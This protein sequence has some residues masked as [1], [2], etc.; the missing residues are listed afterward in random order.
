MYVTATYIPSGLPAS[1]P[2]ETENGPPCPQPRS[3]SIR[4][5]VKDSGAGMSP[6]QLS[7]LFAEGVQFDANKLQAGGE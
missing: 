4:I 3:G 5:S 6:E 1:K 7:Q 2:P